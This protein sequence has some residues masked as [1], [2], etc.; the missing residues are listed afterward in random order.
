[1][2]VDLA[3]RTIST[4]RRRMD[5]AKAFTLFAAMAHYAPPGWDAVRALHNT[6]LSACYAE[7]SPVPPFSF[8]PPDLHPHSIITL[9]TGREYAQRGIEMGIALEKQTKSSSP[10]LGAAYAALAF[11]HHAAGDWDSALSAH[12][13]VVDLRSNAW[14]SYNNIGLIHSGRGD[15]EA[16]VASFRLAKATYSA[17]QNPAA[18]SLTPPF[19]VRY[20]LAYAL[21]RLHLHQLSLQLPPQLPNDDDGENEEETALETKTWEDVLEELNPL[22]SGLL[23]ADGWEIYVLS[24]F[25]LAQVHLWANETH[26]VQLLLARIQSALDHLSTTVSTTH[27]PTPSWWAPSVARKLAILHRKLS[28]HL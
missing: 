19:V 18:P 27:D 10:H 1:M 22:G 17:S 28:H 5:D 13:Q 26:H 14:G 16:A 2:I 7:S 9:E 21:S 8:L 3:F 4:T 6:A 24:L 11:T 25:N 20:N 23:H 12:L 15:Y